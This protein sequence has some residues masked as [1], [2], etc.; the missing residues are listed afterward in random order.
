MRKNITCLLL[1]ILTGATNLFSQD[2]VLEASN[3]EEL[4]FNVRQSTPEM[5]KFVNGVEGKRVLAYSRELLE[6]YP[7]TIKN[8]EKI[9]FVSIGYSS[10][11]D[12]EKNIE[13]LQI[14]P[15]LE[16]LEI[17]TATQFRQSDI[18]DSLHIPDNLKNLPNLRYLQL[19]GTFH[20]DY[21]RLF[22]KLISFSSLEYLGLPFA[23][24]DVKIPESFKI[25]KE[26][27]GIKI[28][29]FKKFIFPN[30]MEKMEKLESIVLP[31]ES[32]EDIGEE[33]IKF[34]TLPALRNLVLNYVKLDSMNVRAF[35][36]LSKLEKLHLL[37]LEIENLQYL[38]DNIPRENNIKELRL[39]NTKFQR[40]IEDYSRLKNLENLYMR[41]PAGF[42]INVEETLYDLTGLK[43]LTIHT[44]SLISVSE[45][46]GNL[47][48]LE[49]LNLSENNLISLPSQIGKLKNLKELNL[50]YNSLI[51]LPVQIGEIK[52]LNQLDLS[53]NKLVSL[54]STFSQLDVLVLL[55]LGDNSI[56]E[57]P[58]DFGNLSNLIE[59]N[60]ANNELQEL[61]LTFGN[62]S[63]LELLFLHINY[64]HTLEAEIGNLTSL[65]RLNLE[66]NFLRELPPS[67]SHLR[68][69]E[70]LHLG[71]NNLQKLPENFGALES[72]EEVYLGGNRNN[73]KPSSYDVSI[74]NFIV[75]ES[76]P[77]REFNEIKNFPQSF[78]KLENLER[79]YLPGIT[80][81]NEDSLFNIFFRVSSKNYR[82]DLNNT[83]ISHLPQT[84]W[85]N[86]LA[87][88]LNLGG[89]VI[90][91]IP[92]DI[93]NAPHLNELIF[94]LSE[95]DGLSYALRGKEQLNAFYEEQGFID[96]E[97]LPK[98][99]LM[100]KAYLNIAFNRKYTNADAEEIL[101]LIEKAFLLDSTYTEKNIVASDYA[102]ALLS[103]GKYH[104]A[105]TYY[106]RAIERDTTRGPYV[107]NYIHPNFRN[108]AKAHLAVGDTLAAIKGLEHVSKRFSSGD[109]AEAALL[110]KAIG[111]DSLAVDF[112]L[113]GEKFYKNYIQHNLEA[114]QIDFGYQLSLLELYII[115]EDLPAALDYLNYLKNEQIQQKDKQLL[116]RYLEHVLEIFQD[117]AKEAEL[118]SFTQEI[119]TTGTEISSWSFDLLYSWL[120][121]TNLKEIKA[122]RIKRLTKAMENKK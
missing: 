53:Y 75:D 42:N 106:D 41:S 80:T 65:K 96:F 74:G 39:L 2:I 85:E 24:E 55:N 67:F 95:F 5:V 114:G 6:K 87:G 8:P 104:K 34:S 22:L 71:F 37:N 102:D 19:S 29:G 88:S 121:L 61:P 77:E 91:G 59:L 17:K 62:L 9:K 105:I 35:Q 15:N 76:R 3:T 32:Y 79:V 44:D 36:K 31:A 110:A 60:L 115:K 52:S 64:L 98:T 54:P 122:T 14:F 56:I 57:L 43:S 119:Q 108:R 89:N 47:K 51:S 117:K 73:S 58:A 10:I 94:R 92:A 11:E 23:L 66:D 68:S 1:F 82:L 69:L 101:K 27:K 48:N 111:E 118:K 50:S 72:L 40:G 21:D 99:E 97:G 93:I 49:K 25:F 83:N 33:I 30:N 78:S 63:K 116:L 12:L 70:Y 84:G 112:F 81:L 46:I 86:F 18:K 26:L 28:A 120:N 4:F 107:L 90:S 16:Y 109:W 113:E 45:K 13:G 7:D 100:A 38:V 103:T 20:I